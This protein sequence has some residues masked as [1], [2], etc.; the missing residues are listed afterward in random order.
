MK[1]KSLTQSLAADL[2]FRRYMEVS[3][4]SPSEAEIARYNLAVF[5]LKQAGVEFSDTYERIADQ[6]VRS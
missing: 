1:F 3:S 4:H 5:N 2:H 6:V